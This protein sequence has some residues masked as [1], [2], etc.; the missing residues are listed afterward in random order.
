M[1]I[2]DGQV[3]ILTRYHKMQY[4]GGSRLVCRFLPAVVGDLLVAYQAP[5]IQFARYL[6]TVHGRKV[7]QSYLFSDGAQPW[8]D[9]RLTRVMRRETALLLG[10]ELILSSY[11]HLAIAIDRRHLR[12]MGA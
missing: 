12:R 5:E 7:G 3:M 4:S 10:Q 2:R 11:R 1:I 8:K 9:D 6:E